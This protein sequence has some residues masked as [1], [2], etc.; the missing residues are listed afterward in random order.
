MRFLIFIFMCLLVSSQASIL[1]QYGLN[2]DIKEEKLAQLKIMF[3][4]KSQI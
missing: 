4:T 3:Q 1:I 2:Y